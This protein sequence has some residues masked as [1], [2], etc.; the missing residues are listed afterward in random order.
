[1]GLKAF[2]YDW[3]VGPGGEPIEITCADMEKMMS[4][5]SVRH[6]AFWAAVNKVARSISKCEIKTYKNGVEVY[7]RDYYRLNIAPNRNTNNVEFLQKLVSKMYMSNEALIVSVND[8]LFVADNFDKEKFA[9]KNWQ[10]SNVV[11]DEYNL[12]KKFYMDEVMYFRLN[13]ENV[14]QVIDNVYESYGAMIAAG[15]KYFNKSAGARG[16]V[17]VNAQLG[18]TAEEKKKIEESMTKRF[19]ALQNDDDAIVPLPSGYSFTNL[20]KGD[21]NGRLYRELSNDVLDMTAQSFGIPPVLLRG[22]VAG[23]D[24]VYNMYLTD[25]ID[26]LASLIQSEINKQMYG[27]RA[28]LSGS[29]VEIDTS[30]IKH[31]ETLEAMTKLDKAVGSGVLTIN[32]ARKEINKRPS[33]DTNCDKHF[34]TKN[35]GEIGDIENVADES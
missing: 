9:F 5:Y 35:Y 29:K 3:L 17:N 33:S 14:K 31:I 34:I 20:N 32:E 15:K 6:F 21:P 11:I 23:I 13:N 26:P 27:E 25:C 7:E 28:F 30:K 22:E 18:G 10:F 1:M 24:E 8:E 4:D 16:I 19:R 2:L 12:N